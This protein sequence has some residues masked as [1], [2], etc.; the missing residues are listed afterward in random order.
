VSG[1]T[2]ASRPAPA[3]GADQQQVEAVEASGF[4][5]LRWLPHVVSL[6]LFALVIHRELAAYRPADLLAHLAAI[7][8]S[9]LALALAAAALGYGTLTLFDPLAL[10]YLGKSLPYRQTGLASFIG[11]AFS[12]NLG[13]GWL[14]GAPSAI[15]CTASGDCRPSRSGASSP[16]TPSRRSSASAPSWRSPAS[17]SRVRSR[18]SCACPGRS[19]W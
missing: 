4:Q 5:R 13:L 18:Q 12:H 14:S 19:W 1:A 8:T 2:P 11:Y 7:P 6:L 10:H 15:A 9:A 3:T 17:A 16:S